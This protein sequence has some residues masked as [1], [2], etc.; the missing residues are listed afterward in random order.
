MRLTEGPTSKTMEY[1]LYRRDIYESLLP[2][3]P[4]SFY[5]IFINFSILILPVNK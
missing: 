4:K 1:S 5:D 2:T 3:K